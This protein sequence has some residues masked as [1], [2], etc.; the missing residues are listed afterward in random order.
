MKKKSFY[1][2]WYLY[3][4]FKKRRNRAFWIFVSACI[5]LDAPVLITNSIIERYNWNF[6]DW[7]ITPS[8]ILIIL[9]I[10]IIFIISFFFLI[11]DFIISLLPESNSRKTLSYLKG[12]TYLIDNDLKK[13]E[14]INEIIKDHCKRYKLDDPNTEPPDSGYTLKFSNKD[15][16]ITT[17]VFKVVVLFFV[18]TNLILLIYNATALIK[19]DVN[20]SE[21]EFVFERIG[22]MFL[23]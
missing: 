7:F 20:I 21:V 13:T 17:I 4:N 9:T 22:K 3:L 11:I 18:V 6:L 5:F 8:G 19:N 15:E 16:H 12:S 1:N 23:Y 2:Y 14:S 10:W